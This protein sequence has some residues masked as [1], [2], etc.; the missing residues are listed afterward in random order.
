MDQQA[1]IAQLRPIIR[2]AFSLYDKNNVGAVAGEF[3]DICL[4]YF[5]EV[6]FIL[7][8]LGLFPSESEILDNI[9]KEVCFYV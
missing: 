8:Y 2:E 3:V 9:M 4:Y 6:C 1:K 5:R 7:R